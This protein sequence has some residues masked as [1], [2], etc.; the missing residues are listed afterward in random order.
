LRAPEPTDQLLAL[1]TE[2][3]AGD[4]FDPAVLRL[5]PDDFHDDPEISDG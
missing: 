4:D 3:A 1:A 2:H 5:F